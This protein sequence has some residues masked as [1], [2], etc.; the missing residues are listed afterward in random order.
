MVAPRSVSTLCTVVY[1]GSFLYGEG[2][3]HKYD[4]AKLLALYH[5]ILS[6][7]HVLIAADLSTN[8]EGLE[9]WAILIDLAGSDAVLAGGAA[10]ADKLYSQRY[11]HNLKESLDAPQFNC[12]YTAQSPERDLD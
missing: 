4:I 9:T 10:I 8:R 5:R 12:K 11:I 2:R 3:H 7:L 1:Q 6:S